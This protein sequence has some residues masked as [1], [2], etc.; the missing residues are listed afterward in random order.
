[1]SELKELLSYLKYV[2]LSED[3]TKTTIIRNSSTTLEN[4]AFMRVL[5]EN[6]SEL[7]WNIYNMKGIRLNY[8]TH[9]INM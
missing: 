4:D 5:R 2:F 7:R 1:M 6:R 3:F 9:K 8:Y